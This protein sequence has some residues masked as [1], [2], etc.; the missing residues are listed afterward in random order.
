MRSML[1]LIVL[2]WQAVPAQATITYLCRDGSHI[3]VKSGG[4]ELL[5]REELLTKYPCLRDFHPM[6]VG[7]ASAK[8]REEIAG[9][10]TSVAAFPCDRPDQIAADGKRCGGR[11]ASSRPGGRLGGGE[12]VDTPESATSGSSGS[13]R[14][15]PGR[16]E[17]RRR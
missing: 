15:Q 12:T 2:V 11:A 8:P 7:A 10:S 9:L 14:K 3:T 16:S 4:D 13:G 17:S 1:F 6:P 5:V